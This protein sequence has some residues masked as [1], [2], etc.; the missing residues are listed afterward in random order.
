MHREGISE[1]RAKNAVAS[2]LAEIRHDLPPIAR[3][4]A[5][6]PIDLPVATRHIVAEVAAAAELDPTVVGGVVGVG[7]SGGFD[8]HFDVAVE[9][10]LVAGLKE[11]CGS[12]RS[13]V[14]FAAVDWIARPAP[15]PALGLEYPPEHGRIP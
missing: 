10:C 11:A 7:A 4:K 9:L 8:G 14:D 13:S 5:G 6:S 15:A 12:A 1:G 3:H 2:C